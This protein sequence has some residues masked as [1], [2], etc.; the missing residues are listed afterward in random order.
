MVVEFAHEQGKTAWNS[1]GTP[2]LSDHL[3]EYPTIK[4][5]PINIGVVLFKEV[6]NRLQ[7][8]LIMRSTYKYFALGRD[9]V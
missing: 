7:F 6:L 1:A 2:F 3:K 5:C 4:N 9:Q 8:T